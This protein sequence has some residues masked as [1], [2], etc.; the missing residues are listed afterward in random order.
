MLYSEE[1]YFALLDFSYNYIK[2]TFILQQ[3]EVIKPF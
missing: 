2:W 1:M 3:Y